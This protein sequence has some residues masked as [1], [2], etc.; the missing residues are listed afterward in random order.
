MIRFRKTTGGAANHGASAGPITA[1]LTA[2][3]AREPVCEEECG[4]DGNG[5]FCEGDY[6]IADVK[7]LY[8]A[9]V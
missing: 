2:R 5:V 1:F 7:E 3:E 6:K 8:K 9:G 4:A